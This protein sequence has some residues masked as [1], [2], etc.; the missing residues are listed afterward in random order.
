MT[1]LQS[2]LED[3]NAQVQGVR[4]KVDDDD[5]D[6][7]GRDREEEMAAGQGSFEKGKIIPSHTSTPNESHS[8][9]YPFNIPFQHTIEHIHTKSGWTSGCLFVD[10]QR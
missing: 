8:L 6:A 4:H 7:A 2:I 5:V 10:F 3:E 9:T 1:I